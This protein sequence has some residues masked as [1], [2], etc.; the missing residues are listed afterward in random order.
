MIMNIHCTVCCIS[1]QLIKV[2]DYYFLAIISWL[3]LYYNVPWGDRRKRWDRDAKLS[4]PL[5]LLL[6]FFLFIPRRIKKVPFLPSSIWPL[7]SR[8]FA[9]IAKSIYSIRQRRKK[10]FFIWISHRSLLPSSLCN[11]HWP[12]S[13]TIPASFAL[14]FLLWLKK[15]PT[16]RGM[17]A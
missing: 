9:N 5:V 11:K 13:I 3:P 6:L 8:L 14:S 7:Q 2:L 10:D 12:N 1:W 15:G 16:E 4:P 17:C